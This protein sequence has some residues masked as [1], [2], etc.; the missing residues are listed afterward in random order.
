V[1][2]EP[3]A[4]AVT[5]GPGVTNGVT[6]LWQVAGTC[7]S[8]VVFGGRSEFNEFELG[9]LQDTKRIESANM[10]AWHFATRLPA[11]WGRRILSSPSISS[12][13]K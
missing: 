4:A 2:G 12:I 1:T 7:V 6:G 13:S 11:E 9:S 3:A 10:S 8:M 5:A